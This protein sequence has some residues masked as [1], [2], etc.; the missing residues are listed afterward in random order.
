MAYQ[1]LLSKIKSKGKEINYRNNLKCQE[2]LLPNN[3]LAL[4]EQRA[5]FSYRARMNN[6]KYNYSGTNILETCKCGSDMTNIYLY[7][8]RLLDESERTV[9]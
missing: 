7:E 3:I 1:Y 4:Q 5:I 9:D 8:C 2:Y 6:L